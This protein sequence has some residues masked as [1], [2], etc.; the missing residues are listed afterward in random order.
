MSEENAY[1]KGYN[2]GLKKFDDRITE[3]EKDL[4]KEVNS[5]SIGM[6]SRMIE[7]SKL[8]ERIEKLE[9]KFETSN[10][11]WDEHLI[12]VEKQCKIGEKNIFKRI[13]KLE[14]TIVEL[15]SSIDGY[16]K[17]Y[18]YN[19][20]RSYKNKEVLRENRQTM[21]DIICDIGLLHPEIRDVCETRLHQLQDKL[22]GEKTVESSKE[23]ICE[24]HSVGLRNSTKST[25]SRSPCCMYTICIHRNSEERCMHGLI[26]VEG[27]EHYRTNP[28]E[29][30]L[31]P[32]MKK[33]FERMKEV[34]EPYNP[35][36]AKSILL[37]PY[38]IVVEK[39]DLID[40]LSEDMTRREFREKY[41]E[42]DKE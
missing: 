39:E 12:E 40:V 9:K 33:D 29:Q 8:K 34:A 15:K 3:L 5:T 28:S 24:S 23:S 17:L 25:V 6:N 36:D 31:P 37:E 14:K 11:S 1:I 22:V 10:E 30:D 38:E 26:P 21:R 2:D 16:F 42:E 35:Y 18:E 19:K 27:C 4:E 13:D 7:S 20:I 32:N 41:L